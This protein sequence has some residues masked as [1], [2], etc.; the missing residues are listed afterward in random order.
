MAS[1]NGVFGASKRTNGMA[2]G[3]KE[4]KGIGCCAFPEGK[5]LRR[6]RGPPFSK[7]VRRNEKT[8][9]ILPTTRAVGQ[10][11][12]A[13]AIYLFFFFCERDGFTTAL[14]IFSAR[15]DFSFDCSRKS[16]ADTNVTLS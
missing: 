7:I 10:R 14:S 2:C 6:S 11:R 15:L 8:I 12:A 1:T 3:K 5:R 13:A 9:L 16:C 4:E